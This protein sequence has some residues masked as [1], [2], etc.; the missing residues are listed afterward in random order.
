MSST[1]GPGGP[2][3]GGQPAVPQPRQGS[4]GLA[5]GALILG[6]LSI[7]LALFL[8]GGLTGLIAVVLGIAGISRARAMGG[9]GQGLA[10]GGIVT[11]L[12][13]IGLAVLVVAG[14]VELFQSPEGQQLL[15]EIEASL[16][17]AEARS[18]E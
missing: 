7:P 17:E 10:I 11:G 5:I 9:T 13:A 6:L 12:L 1:S 8:F 16:S 3:W 2:T 14:A 18:S 4:N 15:E